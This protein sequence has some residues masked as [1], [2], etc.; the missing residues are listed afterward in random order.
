MKWETRNLLGVALVKG[1]HFAVMLNNIPPF[2]LKDF[3]I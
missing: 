2:K 1:H 3:P